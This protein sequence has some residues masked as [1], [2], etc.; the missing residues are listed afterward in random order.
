MDPDW[1]SDFQL[2][3]NAFRP[4]SGVLDELTHDRL[5]DGRVTLH[6]SRIGY[7]AN[8]DSVLLAS[9]VPGSASGNWLE[10]GSG[11]GAVLLC[12]ALRCAN[13]NWTGVEADPSAAALCRTNLE[14]ANRASQE[15]RLPTRLQMI[16]AD[17]RALP[18][19]F[20]ERFAGVVMNPPFTQDPKT[21]RLPR[22]ERRH[23]LINSLPLAQWISTAHWALAAQGAL[24]LIHQASMIGDILQALTP[25]FGAVE[26]VPVFGRA[27]R[28]ARRIL[29]RAFKG[30]KTQIKLLAPLYLQRIGPD[31]T[32]PS[33]E[34]QSLWL[35]AGFDWNRAML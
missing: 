8:M 11:N 9:A 7:R 17:L 34:A 31:R 29:L 21:M 18:S 32:K 13:S 24:I 27:D 25:S 26:L 28:P 23:A 16:E 19:S 14:M 33:P 1:Q 6:Q 20:A 30:R 2:P 4:R 12:A 5:L 10:L 22:P 15:R 35:G 3:D